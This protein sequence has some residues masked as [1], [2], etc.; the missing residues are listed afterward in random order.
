MKR[1]PDELL[2][3]LK[4]LP[5]FDQASFEG[6]HASGEQVTSIRLN[7]T[8]V[9]S[10]FLDFEISG[11][12]SVPWSSY[13]YY[14]NERPVFTLDPLLHAGCYYVQ[15]AS[16]MFLEQ[17][18]RQTADLS[19]PLKILD[20][21]AAP[22]G[23]STLLQS[24]ITAD[25]LLV[26]NEVIKSRV[27]V[28]QENII[29]W[30]ATNVVVTHNDAKVFAGLENYF[31]VMIVDAPCS[32]SGLFRK[33]VAAIDEWSKEN[34]FMCSL[35][36]K[37]IVADAMPCLKKN[38]ILIYCTCS[39]SEE[40]DEKVLDWMMEEFA[41][42]SLQLTVEKE[43]NIVETQ[44]AIHKGFGYRFYPNKLKGEGFFIACLRKGDGSENFN[45]YKRSG[46]ERPS[47]N[48]ELIVKDWL[49]PEA[50]ITLM[51]HMDDIIGLPL[52]FE[53]DIPV[54][55]KQLYIRQAGVMIGKS[56]SNELIPDHALALSL[57]L[58]E[59]IVSVSL[60]K[61]T[62]LQ[63]LR[64]ADV[65]IDVGRKGWALVKY[66]GYNLGWIKGLGNRINNYYPKEWRIL[67]R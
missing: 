30:G 36:Q 47:K 5:G 3:S 9:I 11:F 27:N 49:K 43:W 56:G 42:D 52:S 16:S 2:D 21:C 13:G 7:P 18:L 46:L 60:N 4:T 53:K 6:I 22:G 24:L 14:L 31:D 8:K 29:K 1:L 63:Y 33:D 55:Q 67:M 48:E 34:V 19:K 58:H 66:E 35:R 15:E 62:A 45:N 54:L 10:G 40:E 20:L 17:A 38:G 65:F 23:K 28:L 41:V 61:E 37:R 50:K 57:L 25:S 59:K 44:S 12:T 32:G 39:Y 26:C 64:K 51:K